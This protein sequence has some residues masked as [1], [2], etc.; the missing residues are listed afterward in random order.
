MEDRESSD[1]GAVW[2]EALDKYYA[3]TKTNLK[4][5][6]QKSWTIKALKEEQEKEIQQFTRFRHDGKSVDKLR[7]TISKNSAIIQGV[8]QNIAN[9][10]SAVTS[11]FFIRVLS[12]QFS[13]NII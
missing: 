9:A 4:M 3:S 13:D 12:R 2:G 8:A 10:A 1:I 5:M 11:L 6:P 7:S